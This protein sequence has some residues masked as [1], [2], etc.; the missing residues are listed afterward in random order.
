MIDAYKTAANTDRLCVRVVTRFI[1]LTLSCYYICS[2][3]G[4]IYLVNFKN[5]GDMAQNQ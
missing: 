2:K 3:K 5:L 4:Q 1:G